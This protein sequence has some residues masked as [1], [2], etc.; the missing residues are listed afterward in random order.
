M[1][2]MIW[3]ITSVAPGPLDDAVLDVG[4]VLHVDDP[5]AAVLQVA[6]HHVEESVTE[7]MSDMHRSVEIRAADVQARRP[8]FQRR[9]RF[10]ALG[11]GVVGGQNGRFTSIASSSAVSSHPTEG[12]SVHRSSAR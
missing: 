10:L 7:G 9:K 8:L 4:E 2:S 5:V 6:A 1:I 3:G 11:E 12:R